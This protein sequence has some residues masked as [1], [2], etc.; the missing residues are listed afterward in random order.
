VVSDRNSSTAVSAI[1]G[2]LPKRRIPPC[3]DACVTNG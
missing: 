3:Y 2:M 1:K